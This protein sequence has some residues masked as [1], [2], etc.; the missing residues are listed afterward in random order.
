MPGRQ[1]ETVLA[2]D[3]SSEE[4]KLQRVRVKLGKRKREHDNAAA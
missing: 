4:Q 3:S 2:M 1:G